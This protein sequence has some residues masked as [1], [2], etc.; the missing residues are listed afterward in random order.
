MTNAELRKRTKETYGQEYVI[1]LHG[2]TRF[3]GVYYVIKRLIFLH[4]RG[5]MVTAA[6]DLLRS[7]LGHRAL[8]SIFMKML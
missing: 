8:R 6:T 4:G 1:I 5:D 7:C 2:E 3:A